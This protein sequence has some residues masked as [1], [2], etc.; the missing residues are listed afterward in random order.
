ML[1]NQHLMG[2]REIE[3]GSWSSQV[4][5]PKATAIPSCPILPNPLA[6]TQ[7]V[8][9]QALVST[10]QT[11]QYYQL[12]VGSNTSQGQITPTKYQPQLTFP[13][14]LRLTQSSIGRRLLLPSLMDQLPLFTLNQQHQAEWPTYHLRSWFNQYCLL[15]F[16]NVSLSFS[17]TL[18]DTTAPINRLPRRH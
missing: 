13:L 5:K 15:L 3:V 1:P 11:V 17:R 16:S 12:A 7:D 18:L 2:Q 6:S 8:N 14:H 4:V 9:S 10:L